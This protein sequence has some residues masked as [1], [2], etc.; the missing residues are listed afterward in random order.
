MRVNSRVIFW[1]LQIA[2]TDCI[3]ALFFP[4][5]HSQRFMLIRDRDLIY[6]T[7][8]TG[9]KPLVF[10]EIESQSHSRVE[11]NPGRLKRQTPKRNFSLCADL[12][13][14]LLWIMILEDG[15]IMPPCD[16][17]SAPIAMNL[18]FWKHLHRSYEVLT[19]NTK[20]FPFSPPLYMNWLAV[21]DTVRLRLRSSPQWAPT[22]NMTMVKT[23]TTIW[24]RWL[25]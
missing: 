19:K 2:K 5:R 17:L 18:H 16:N 4:S 14:T 6:L 1:I 10:K 11:L 13:P 22:N 21:T 12:S 9:T 24:L 7:Y 20:A 25:L 23:H 3:T 8:D 15:W